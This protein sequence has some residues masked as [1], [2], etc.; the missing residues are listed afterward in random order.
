MDERVRI[1]SERLTGAHFD[2]FTHP[3]YIQEMSGES[4]QLATSKKAQHR[5]SH[6]LENQ[7]PNAP[8]KTISQEDADL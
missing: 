4:F 2:R 1:G 3:G 7:A 5:Q 6:A 8:T